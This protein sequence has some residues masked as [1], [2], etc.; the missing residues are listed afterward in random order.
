MNPYYQELDDTFRGEYVRVTAGN[1][2]YEGYARMFN[3]NDGGVIL[4]GAM[5][6]GEHVGSV[7]LPEYDTIEQADAPEIM[8]VPVDAL[9]DSP[10]SARRYTDADLDEYARDLRTRGAMYSFPT[11]RPVDDSKYELVGGHRRTE[12][13]RRAGFETIPV[14]LITLSDWDALQRFVD[15]HI[16]LSE[17][18]L[19]DGSDET[20][21]WYT[22]DEITRSLEA[23]QQRWDTDQLR[24]IPALEVWLEDDWALT[25]PTQRLK[26]PHRNSQS[27]RSIRRDHRP[28]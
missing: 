15:E 23:M 26:L 5:R 1:Q 21:G 6:N 4:H 7:E 3:F 22:A 10:Y 11:A 25:E 9:R 28:Q 13:A 19:N 27:S 14:R 20:R 12:A 18:E 2:T 16:P 24:E 8:D 17:D